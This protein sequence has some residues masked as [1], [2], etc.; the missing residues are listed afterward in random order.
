[1]KFVKHNNYVKFEIKDNLFMKFFSIF[2]MFMEKNTI[3]YENRVYSAVPYTSPPIP[4]G[5]P[6]RVSS[7]RDTSFTY[8]RI[9]FQHTKK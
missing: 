1:M 5:P 2:G 8:L 6:I 9:L 4:F 3:Y 7:A